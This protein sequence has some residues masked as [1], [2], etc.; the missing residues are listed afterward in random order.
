MQKL[1]TVIAET[2][3]E[4]LPPMPLDPENVTDGNPDARGVILVQSADRKVSC[5]LWQCNP[6]KFEYTM[7]WDEIVHMLEGELTIT[8]EG[9][10]NYTLAPGDVAYFPTGLKIFCQIEKKPVRKVFFVRT[11]EPLDPQTLSIA[12]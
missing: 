4:T 2:P 9:G 11:A 3:P 10:K 1:T 6:S 5:G 8:E 7:G 12:K